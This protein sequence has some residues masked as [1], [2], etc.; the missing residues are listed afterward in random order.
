[1]GNCLICPPWR[2]NGK[3]LEFD[4]E[5]HITIETKAEVNDEMKEIGTEDND[6]L[7]EIEFGQQTSIENMNCTTFP[8]TGELSLEEIKEQK[9]INNM[10]IKMSDLQARSTPPEDLPSDVQNPHSN[11]QNPPSNVQN[12]PSNVQN[13]PSND[14]NSQKDGEGEKSSKIGSTTSISSKSSLLE[15]SQRSCGDTNS[16][17]TKLDL[18]Q[19]TFEEPQIENSKE[20]DTIK[21]TKAS[22]ENLTFEQEVYSELEDRLKEAQEEAVDDQDSKPNSGMISL[23]IASQENFRSSFHMIP[24]LS[25]D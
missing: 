24:I 7:H 19:I 21:E 14:Q 15:D 3:K 2:K 20:D 11:V 5:N 12:P 9:D 8:K 1:M 10:T 16:S 17:S 18:I 22:S 6:T 4:P 23:E 25:D 13:P